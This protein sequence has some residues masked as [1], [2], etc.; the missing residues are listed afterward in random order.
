MIALRRTYAQND[1]ANFLAALNAVVING[2]GHE[3]IFEAWL[4]GSV[5]H[6]DDP[7]LRQ[8]W[9]DVSEAPLLGAMATMVVEAM[10]LQFA[11]HVLA[12]DRI[13]ADVLDE[14]Q[15]KRPIPA[16]NL[17]PERSEGAFVR[18]TARN[19]PQ[20]ATLWIDFTNEGPGDAQ[21]ITLEA[22][23][24]L[25]PADEDVLTEGEAER[26][27]PV[28]RLRQGEKVS[29]MAALTMGSPYEYEVVVGWEDPDGSRREEDFRIDLLST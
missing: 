21:N 24:P 15:L 27:F 28:P 8:R 9:K 6:D 29:L 13:V 16:D 4:Y 23:S 7:V 5:F 14:P 25:T 1:G 17:P 26:K 3:E 22:V 11:E 19:R 18:V 12:L 2:S 20:K 10:V